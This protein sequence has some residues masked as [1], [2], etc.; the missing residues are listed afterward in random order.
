[1]NIPEPAEWDLSVAGLKATICGLSDWALPGRVAGHTWCSAHDYLAEL[2]RHVEALA[3]N[4][5]RVMTV[6]RMTVAR[7]VIAAMV[8]AVEAKCIQARQIRGL[9]PLPFVTADEV[10]EEEYVPRIQ[11]SPPVKGAKKGGKPPPKDDKK[12]KKVKSDIEPAAPLDEATA[13]ALAP[14]QFALTREVVVS[15]IA[16]LETV[17][18]L[19][20]A[21]ATWV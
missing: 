1:M 9:P 11:I 14:I 17:F 20:E 8:D 6:A 2:T 16:D 10:P 12:N 7:E 15:A 3:L 4:S 19:C 5:A 21:E 18:P 13:A